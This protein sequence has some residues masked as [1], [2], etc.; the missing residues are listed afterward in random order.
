MGNKR[1]EGYIATCVL[2][3]VLCMLFSLFLSFVAAVNVIHISK[4][5]TRN[6]LDS[7]VMQN[8]VEIYNSLKCYND[9]TDTLDAESFRA[10]FC[11]Y[12]SLRDTGTE[13][14]ASTEQ[15]KEKYKIKNLSVSFEEEGELK[16]KVDYV[17]SVPVSFGDLR[18]V[19]A[20]APINIVTVY[21]SKF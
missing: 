2:I 10:Y 7:F 18:L 9:N 19:N 4:R 20:Q 14:I 3:V 5:N 13:L 21:N 15:G 16:L 11:E 1:A 12:N 6:V 8:S 17:L